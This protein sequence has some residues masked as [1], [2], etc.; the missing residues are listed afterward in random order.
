MSISNL[1]E[2]DTKKSNNQKRKRGRPSVIERNG[3]PDLANEVIKM[4]NLGFSWSKIA[5][6]LGISRTSARRLCQKPPKVCQNSE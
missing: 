3:N 4:R 5:N 2:G 1:F 6:E